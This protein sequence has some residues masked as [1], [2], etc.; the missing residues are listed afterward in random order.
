MTTRVTT[1]KTA[2]KPAAPAPADEHAG[3]GGSYVRDPDTGRRTLQQR[4]KD[5]ATPAQP[6]DKE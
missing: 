5:R 1:R 3:K 6:A 2:A 4:T